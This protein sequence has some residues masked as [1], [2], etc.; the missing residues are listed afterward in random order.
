MLAPAQTSFEASPV[1]TRGSWAHTASRWA[2]VRPLDFAVVSPEASS[3]L[4][5]PHD[6]KARAVAATTYLRRLMGM[7]LSCC[8]SFSAS[9]TSSPFE[10]ADREFFTRWMDNHGHEQSGRP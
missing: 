3:D 9:K 7:V 4:V 5:P 2:A 1:S 10:P 6:T 8:C